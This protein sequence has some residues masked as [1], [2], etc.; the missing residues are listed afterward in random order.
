MILKL[1]KGATAALVLAFAFE[2][3]SLWIQFDRGAFGRGG[4][5]SDLF[6]DQLGTSPAEVV[7]HLNAGFG[8]A[9]LACLGCLFDAKVAEK[10]A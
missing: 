5:G 4:W 9:V 7:F 1:P 10:D 6:K 8:L 3:L 2:L